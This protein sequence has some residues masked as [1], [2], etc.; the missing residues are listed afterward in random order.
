MVAENPQGR[1]PDLDT[2][3]RARFGELSQAEVRLLAA[4]PN[5]QLAVCGS[6]MSDADPANDPAN[7]GTWAADR[8]IRADLIRWLCV[9]RI[10]REFVDPMGIRAY[11]AR[12][13]GA[14]DLSGVTVPFG[15]T[16]WHCSMDHASLHS[17]EIPLLDL[18][19]TWLQS[20]FADAVTVKGAVY[21]RNGFRTE[22]QV[23]LLGARIGGDLDCSNAAVENPPQ[24]DVPGSGIAVNADRAVVKGTVF[25][26]KGFRAQGDV[27]LL[28]ANIGGDLDCSNAT[29]ANP[30][31]P[32]GSGSGIA[33]NADGIDVK[34]NMFLNHNFHAEGQVRLLGAQ[35][36]MTLDCSNAAVENPPQADVP[37]SGIAVNADRAVVKGAVFLRDGF[38]AQGDVRL[39][40]ANIGG[41][42]DC[43]NATFANP[44]RPGVPGSG[45]ALAA[46]GIVVKGTVFLNKGFRAEGEV[47]LLGGQV[48]GQLTCTG[49]SISGAMNA[50]AATVK[51]ALRW[52]YIVNPERTTLI[53]NDASVGALVDD[54]KSWPAHG[55]LFLDGFLYERISSGPRDVKN[56]LEWLARQAAFTLQPYR[57]LAKV[58]RDEG[59]N[60]GARIV[61]F[62]MEKRRR[63][64]EDRGP[65]ARAWTGILKLTIGFGYYP[66]RALLWSI[67]L[68]V[69]GCLLFWGGDTVGS[70]APTD[71][72]A[73]GTFRQSG[74]LPPQHE[75]FNALI[76]SFEGSVPLVKLGQV[77]RWQPDPNPRWE[78]QPAISVYRPLC[79]VASPTSLRSFRWVQ[80]CLGWFFATMGV[81]GVTG[82]IRKE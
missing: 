59:D 4:I 29:F 11:G 42:L 71:K 74:Q 51:R 77:D 24:A 41:D 53:L 48:G 47:R 30:P 7:S 65:F 56:R 22:G 28:G 16:L 14:I 78:C 27:R 38:R 81:A 69:V 64:Q 33:L 19:G 9:D 61:L 21:L 5:G 32:G 55:N 57:R 60:A 35:V 2:L 1:P 23:R 44:P 26:N 45:I 17:T 72:D 20:L 25:L 12:I 6:N 3:A 63:H 40:G 68:T 76:Y 54:S 52:T 31:R 73:Y 75:R 8:D 80:T 50:D 70:M 58:L 36:G 15:L 18:Q 13:P 37:G 66:G 43:S 49:G 46:D 67:G 82:I 34:G 62:E 79:R 10:A 39:L